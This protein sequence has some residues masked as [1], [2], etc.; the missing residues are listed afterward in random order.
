ML[1]EIGY[2]LYCR[3][4]Q[5]ALLPSEFVSARRKAVVAWLKRSRERA[6]GTLS[7]VCYITLYCIIVHV[8]I[9]LYIIICDS[10]LYLVSHS[11]LYSR[12]LEVGRACGS[13]SAS[14]KERTISR[15]ACFFIRVVCL[16]YVMLCWYIVSCVYLAERLLGLC[17]PR[18]LSPGSRQ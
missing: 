10:I 8:S 18:F 6:T 1:N 3:H 11:M 9:S 15:S 13:T 7:R 5:N 16:C 2:Y 4:L 14:V 12:A 17:T